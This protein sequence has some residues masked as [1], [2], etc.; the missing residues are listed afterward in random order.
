MDVIVTDAENLPDKTYVSIRIG[1]TRRQGPYR[2]DDAFHFQKS[3]AA[4]LK[5]D[6]FQ[7]IGGKTVSMYSMKNDDAYVEQID[8][9]NEMKV[10]CR[11]E[12]P[13]ADVG[14]E[15]AKAREAR[16]EVTLQATKYLENSGVQ[17]VLQN[18]IRSLLERQPENALDFMVEHLQDQ[19][20]TNRA[21][22]DVPVE[23]SP[24]SADAPPA[25]APEGEAAAAPAVA[26]GEAAP[27]CCYRGSCGRSNRGGCSSG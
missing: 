2:K 12:F 8:M 20:L 1:D 22:K 26:E 13:G 17:P 16:H 9:G 19:Q 18:M 23:E 21:S 10:S 4:T 6:L 14:A 3:E 27:S 11:C 5:L 25:A 15:R 24:A 7:H